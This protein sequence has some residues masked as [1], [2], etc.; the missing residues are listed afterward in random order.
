MVPDMNFDRKEFSAEHWVGHFEWCPIF[1]MELI[2]SDH[3]D[4]G[5]QEQ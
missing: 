4:Y 5:I 1:N 3:V 2:T